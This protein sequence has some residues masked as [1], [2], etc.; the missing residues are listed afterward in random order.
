MQ[1]YSFI[2]VLLND[3][4]IYSKIC[5]NV[6]MLYSLYNLFV[7]FKYFIYYGNNNSNN[8]SLTA[9]LILIVK[10]NLKIKKEILVTDKYSLLK[11]ISLFMLLKLLCF[12]SFAM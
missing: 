2:A 6:A 4:N 9:N 12:M 3:T 11:L 7:L 8:L 10:Y 1:R 5:R